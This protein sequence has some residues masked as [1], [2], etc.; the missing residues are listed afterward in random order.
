M[1]GVDESL[2]RHPVNELRSNRRRIK[3]GCV[4]FVSEASQDL[5]QL[6]SKGAPIRFVQGYAAISHVD[7]EGLGRINIGLLVNVTQR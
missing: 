4:D 6:R 2:R 5:D 3:E 7:H 1:T